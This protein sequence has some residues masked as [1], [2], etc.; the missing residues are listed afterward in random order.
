MTETNDLQEP[1]EIEDM[2][3][4]TSGELAITVR[5][6]FKKRIMAICDRN[7]FMRKIHG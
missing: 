7:G 3:V 1:L 4:L 5:D 2:R 6:Y